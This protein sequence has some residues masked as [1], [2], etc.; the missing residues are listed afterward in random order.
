MP[1]LRA[2]SVVGIATL[3]L[4]VIGTVPWAPDGIYT[5]EQAERGRG[6]YDGACA[7]CHGA[8]LEGGTST[9]LMGELFAASWGRPNLTLDD[10]LFVVRKTMPKDMPGSLSQE[11]YID[12]ITYILQ[13]NGF[14][15][16]EKEL[17][18]DP[19]LMKTV[20]FAAPSQSD[21]GSSTHR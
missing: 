3:S 21:S 11:Q 9:P 7:A 12:V 5:K 6:F 2:N 17:T 20:R 1:R 10:F 19:A 4:A 18:P 15:A 13:Q 8:K 14:P 16:G